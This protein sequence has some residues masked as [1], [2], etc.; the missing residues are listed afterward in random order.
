MPGRHAH[1]SDNVVAEYRQVLKLFR[2]NAEMDSGL[3]GVHQSSLASH[4]DR[5]IHG[6][7]LHGYVHIARLPRGDGYL[8]YL[9]LETWPVDGNV[10]AAN[11]QAVET[12]EAF[13]VRRA[14]V[15]YVRS[16]I[17]KAN[18]RAGDC[19][20]TGIPHGALNAAAELGCTNSADRQYHQ[21]NRNYPR[22]VHRLFP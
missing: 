9:R 21:N 12:V 18:L 11:W 19:C 20:S 22:T 7:Y 10:V 3:G 1:Q 2:V 5:L 15:G 13:R 17:A 14:L 6:R 4:V 16:Q 8:N